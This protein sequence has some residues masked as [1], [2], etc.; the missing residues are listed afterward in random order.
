MT[1]KSKLFSLL[2]LSVLVLVMFG[3]VVSATLTFEDVVC[4][5]SIA[6]DA[7]SF[8]CTFNLINSATE[9][10]VINWAASTVTLD[11]SILEEGDLSFNVDSIG[12]DTTKQV[13][14]TIEFDSHQIGEIEVSF[15]ANN[16]VPLESP[17]IIIPE[18][19]SLLIPDVEITE[20]EIST[21]ITVEN[22]GNVELTDII[23]TA[24]GDFDVE[25]GDSVTINTLTLSGSLAPGIGSDPIT[26]TITTPLD[27]L[28]VGVNEVKITAT[29]GDTYASGKVSTTSPF[30][31]CENPGHLK[32]DIEDITVI[33]GFGDDDD[34]WYPF[35]EIEID[36][37]VESDT[38]DIEDIE[39]EWALYTESGYKL[40]D[41]KEKDF[42]LDDGDD[43]ELTI[44]FKL[45]NRL[46]KL[47]GEGKL[48][49]YV[50]ATGEID[51]DAYGDDKDKTCYEDSQSVE[52]ITNDDFMILDDFQFNGFK[53]GESMELLEPI[54][55]GT[56]LQIT[57][58]VWNIGDDDQDDV[59]VIIYNQELGINQQIEIGDINAFDSEKLE[60]LINIPSDAEE[61]W[62][63]LRFTIYDE[64]NEIFENKKDDL[65]EFEIF[66]KIEGNCIE[67]IVSVYA[68][69]ESGGKAGQELTVKA[70]ITN[71]G[72]ELV[73]Y[74]LEISGEDEWASSVEL[75]Q[76]TIILDAGESK[77]VLITFDVNKDALG[78]QLFNIEVLEGEELI[79]AQP[80]SVSIE[81]AGFSFPG[82]T[83]GVI[84][85]DNWYLWGIGA[86]NVILVLIIISIALKVMKK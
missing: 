40:A 76:S 24:S 71:L 10:V 68:N 4:P 27:D 55:C 32:I 22:T 58:D 61:K 49:F 8:T 31:D 64:D 60:A 85:K 44:S 69:L 3:G 65:S 48:I 28:D 38:Y 14:A 79:L 30:C 39:V 47:E 9:T 34:Y 63:T 45:D 1:M 83:G 5:D 29:S 80:V 35:D 81:K 72:N 52:L 74:N 66:I 53:L 75:S 2:C 62:Y 12:A 11:S 41:D 33:E 51:D 18:S 15:N 82:I 54:S 78:E 56:E 36:L 50:K 42:D 37:I 13:T 73:A 17:I 43:R 25:L 77:E 6:H 84:S 16:V 59:Y 20:G 57:A 23:L 19:S 7:S 26:V 86:L 67:S 21:T 70:I 46:S